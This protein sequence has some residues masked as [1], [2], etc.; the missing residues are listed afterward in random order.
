MV[1]DIPDDEFLVPIGRRSIGST[2]KAPTMEKDLQPRRN[3][4]G[5]NIGESS[6]TA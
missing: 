6:V 1:V 5:R 4:P 3:Q 2:S